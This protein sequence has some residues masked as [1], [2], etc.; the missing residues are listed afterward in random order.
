LTEIACGFIPYGLE[1][2]TDTYSKVSGL[3]SIDKGG[4]KTPID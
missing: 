1:F 2:P 4:V 3:H